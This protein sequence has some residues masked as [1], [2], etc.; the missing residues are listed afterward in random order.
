[1]SSPRAA[2]VYYFPQGHAE[3]ATAAVDLSAARVPALLP[4]RISVVRFM[5]D[6]HSDEVFAKIRLVPIRHGRAATHGNKSVGLI[7][8][9]DALLGSSSTKYSALD[10]QRPELLNKRKVQGKILLCG[11]SFNYIS[12]TASIKKVSQTD[13]SLGVD[14]FVVA[15]ED[16]YPGT[17]FDHVHVN[18]P[19]ILITDVSKT[20]AHSIQELARKEFQKDK[21]GSSGIRFNLIGQLI[22]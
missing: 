14:G 17:K 8:A 7:S 1:M 12:G 16:S 4:Y 20:K 3:P 6:A 19:G 15:V 18:I 22:W 11:Y 13:M 2:A 9:T 21:E 10:C 5:A